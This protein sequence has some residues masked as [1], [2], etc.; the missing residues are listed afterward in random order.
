MCGFGSD[1]SAQTFPVLCSWAGGNLGNGLGPASQLAARIVYDVMNAIGY[2]A[3][4][5]VYS[6]GVGN[7]AATILNGRSVVVYNRGFI[8]GLDSCNRIAPVSVLAHEVGHHANRDTTWSAKFKHPWSRELGADWVSGLAMRRLGISL[9]DALSGI[10]CSF[11]AF[12]PGSESHP[13]S[14]RRLRAVS[15]G[16]YNG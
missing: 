3:Q 5:D 6:G 8:Q 10:F 2:Q 7:A 14:Q 9:E 1:T 12:G 13:D 4:L 15:E 11:G 16:W